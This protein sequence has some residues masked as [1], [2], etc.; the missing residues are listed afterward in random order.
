MK[1]VKYLIILLLALFIPSSGLA[2]IAFPGAEGWGAASVGGRGTGSA[3][4]TFSVYEVT[5]TNDSGAGSLRAAVQ[6]SGPRFV[7]FKTGGTITLSSPLVITNP[8]IT[9]AGQTAPGGGI[10]IKGKEVL[11]ETHDVIIRYMSFRPGPQASGGDVHSVAIYDHNSDNVYNIILDHCSLNWGVDECLGVQYK[12]YNLTVQNSIIAEGMYNSNHSENQYHAKGAMLAGRCKDNSCTLPGGYNYS[13]LRNLVAH[14]DDRAPLI[15]LY[16]DAQVINNVAYNAGSRTVTLYRRGLASASEEHNIVGNYTKEGPSNYDR[17]PYT[18]KLYSYYDPAY[19]GTYGIYVEGNIDVHRTSTSQAET[20]CLDSSVLP[21]YNATEYSGYP[22]V[23]E[24][25]ASQAYADVLAAGGAGNSKM[26]NSDGS[27]T[28]RR[29]A[30]DQRITYEALNGTGAYVNAPSSSFCF[31]LCLSCTGGTCGTAANRILD[32]DD[33]T[34]AGVN[35]TLY[36]LDSDGWP[37]LDTGTGYTDSDH[38]GMPDA[39]ETAMGLDPNNPADAHSD[40]D[41]D[42]YAN[43]E[44]F[45]NGAIASSGSTYN[46]NFSIGSGAVWTFGTTGAGFNVK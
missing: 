4:Y 29:D 13:F 5:N 33:Y 18:A 16:G 41:S 37:D 11:I 27:W 39:W 23:T 7:V 19:P 20:A 22:S 38:D 31:G 46:Y 3:P 42:G 35:L 12:V 36:P 2:T 1:I 28:N 15:D 17:N 9:I 43:L 14:V 24:T 40:M 32:S 10:Q 6:A 26:L 34:A 8:Y 44:E 45:L 30:V 21:Y 25:S